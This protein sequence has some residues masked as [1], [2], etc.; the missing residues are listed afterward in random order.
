[1][2]RPFDGKQVQLIWKDFCDHSEMVEKLASPD[3]KPATLP[4]RQLMA[5][6]VPA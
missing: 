1:M 6:S 5:E 3:V 4:E 2:M